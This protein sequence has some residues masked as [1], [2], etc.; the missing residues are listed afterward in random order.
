[1]KNGNIWKMDFSFSYSSDSLSKKKFVLSQI[2]WASL[3][4]LLLNVFI[5]N[6]RS[7]SDKSSHLPTKFCATFLSM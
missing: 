2:S 7:S 1:M 5:R 6:F 4:I 3:N